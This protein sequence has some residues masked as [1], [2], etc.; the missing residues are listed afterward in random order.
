MHTRIHTPAEGVTSQVTASA[1]PTSSRADGERGKGGTVSSSMRC[2]GRGEG[3]HPPSS[4]G[5]EVND[6]ELGDEA[7]QQG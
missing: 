7:H 4:T 5:S 1:L 2:H 6:A 3:G